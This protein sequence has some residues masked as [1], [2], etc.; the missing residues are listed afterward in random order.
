MDA[1]TQTE[2]DLL[3]ECTL[4]TLWVTV[5]RSHIIHDYFRDQAKDLSV[6]RVRIHLM[7]R[8]ARWK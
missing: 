7:Q 2:R 5:F 6:A 3:T 1:G 8:A 4:H